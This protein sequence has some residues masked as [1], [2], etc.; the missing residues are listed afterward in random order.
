[1][2]FVAKI[3]HNFGKD[4]ITVLCVTVVLG[5]VTGLLYCFGIDNGG[6]CYRNFTLFWIIVN[7]E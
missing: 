3:L 2:E 4:N 6:I 7:A 1:M 5:L